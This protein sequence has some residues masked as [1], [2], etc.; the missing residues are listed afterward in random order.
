MHKELSALESAR[1][2]YE[3]LLKKADA[4]LAEV[5]DFEATIVWAAGDGHVLMNLRTE[6]LASLEC[7]KGK[8]KSNKLTE[9]EHESFAI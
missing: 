7:L 1:G 4:K 2:K 3:S 8:T 5:C 9:K 6:T